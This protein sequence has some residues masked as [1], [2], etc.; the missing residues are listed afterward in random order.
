M[1]LSSST[2]IGVGI[3]AGV[4]TLVLMPEICI[5]GIVIGPEVS[6]AIVAGLVKIAL[7]ERHHQAEKPEDKVEAVAELADTVFEEV[8]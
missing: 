2:I 4:A 8:I 3:L 6:A 1:A 7:P 5:A